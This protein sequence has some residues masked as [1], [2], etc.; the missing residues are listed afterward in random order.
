MDLYEFEARQ[1]DLCELEFSLG[2]IVSSRTARPLSS[3]SY[4]V[5]NVVMAPYSYDLSELE[6]PLKSPIS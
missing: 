5:S 2:Y 4:T 3:S 1:V 6:L